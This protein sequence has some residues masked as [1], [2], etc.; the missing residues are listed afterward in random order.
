MFVFEG[1]PCNEIA[2]TLDV[3]PQSISKWKKA[4][5]TEKSW[6]DK[7]AEILSSPN[8]IREI[9]M[10]ELKVVAEGGTSL[11][12]A[13]ALAKINKVIGD[14]SDKVSAQVV[15]SVF[16]EFDNWMA[17]QDAETAIKFTHY[18]KQFLHYKINQSR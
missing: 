9:L 17:E 8:K 6:D 13:D 3:S 10:R 7:R 16:Q 5:D 4:T 14:L 15:V 18:H 1:I 11:V 2:A 12:D